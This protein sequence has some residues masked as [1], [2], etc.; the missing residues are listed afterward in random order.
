MSFAVIIPMF[1]EEGGAEPCVRR[2][3]EEL[4]RVPQRNVLIVINDGSRDRTWKVLQS[5]APEIEG[6]ILINHPQ[7]RGYGAA[8]K[9]GIQKAGDEG[10]DYVLFMDSDLT[11]DPTDIPKFVEKMEEG[12][13]VIKASR[14]TKG[15]GVHGVPT[16]RIIISRIGNYFAR[17]LYGLPIHDCTNGFRAVRTH[18]LTQMRLRENGFAIIMEELFQAKFLAQRFCEVPYILTARG[19]NSKA[20]S[21]AYSP[22]ICYNYLKYAFKSFLNQAPKHIS[23]SI[24]G[25]GY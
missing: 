12:F 8:L 13:D 14:Y 3:C 15:G 9:T 24:Q 23:Q 11:N 25:G 4:S 20:S 21:F 6:L 2:V 5:I 19:K 1:N 16:R 10:F 18:I 17:F 22:R 7:N